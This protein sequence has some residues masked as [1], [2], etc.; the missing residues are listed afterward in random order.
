M[1]RSGFIM[2][3]LAA[4]VVTL[5]VIWLYNKFLAPKGKSIAD[6]GRAAS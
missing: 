4:A 2:A 1:R 5:A 3:F 6:F